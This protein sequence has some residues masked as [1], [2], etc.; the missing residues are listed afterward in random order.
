VTQT[1]AG[2]IPASAF[3]ISSLLLAS[4]CGHVE[5]RSAEVMFL[6][7][8]EQYRLIEPA[9]FPWCTLTTCTATAQ[10][11][12]QKVYG[13]RLVVRIGPIS[14][15]LAVS[16]R[17]FYPENAPEAHSSPTHDRAVYAFGKRCNLPSI[18]P[19]KEYPTLAPRSCLVVYPQIR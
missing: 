14:C 2:P 3:V 5:K 8:L 13:L 4:A 19:V 11:E 6:Q 7:T 9:S 10:I 15:T 12:A 16:E 1:P 18:A 17:Q